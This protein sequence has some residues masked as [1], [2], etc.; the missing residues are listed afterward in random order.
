M[1]GERSTYIYNLVWYIWVNTRIT[2]QK[3]K[4]NY[5]YVNQNICWMILENKGNQIPQHGIKGNKCLL[6]MM[7]CWI[8]RR[9]RRISGERFYFNCILNI[10]T[11]KKRTWINQ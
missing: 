6:H 10:I 7:L 4:E 11:K 8:S 2:K 9:S 1:K 5:L 3:E